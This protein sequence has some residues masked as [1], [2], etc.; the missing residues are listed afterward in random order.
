VKIRMIWMLILIAFLLFNTLD[1]INTPCSVKTIGV[2]LNP[3]RSEL[4]VAMCDLQFVNSSF[5]SSN[6]NSSGNLNNLR[7]TASFNL[8]AS[9]QI[10][11]M[12]DSFIWQ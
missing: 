7:L 5:V 9:Y 11:I 2:Y 8:L 1:S 3:I 6:I 10:N 4:E 12:H